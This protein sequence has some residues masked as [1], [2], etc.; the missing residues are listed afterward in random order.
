MPD[1]SMLSEAC[2]SC[3]ISQMPKDRRIR[4]LDGHG[5]DDGSDAMMAGIAFCTGMTQAEVQA[6]VMA[7]MMP[8]PTGGC[9]E[10]AGEPDVC[11]DNVAPFL[12][13]VATTTMAGMVSADTD[14]ASLVAAMGGYNV[15]CDGDLSAV[16]TMLGTDTTGSIV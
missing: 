12:E 4:R 2:G 11:E 9:P 5:G 6:A 10:G 16:F 8:E 15:D 1:M 3:V 14:C 7:A 13:Y